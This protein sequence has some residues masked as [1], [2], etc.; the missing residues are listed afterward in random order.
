[1]TGFLTRVAQSALGL[2]PVLQVLGASRYAPGPDLLTNEIASEEIAEAGPPSPAARLSP[3]ARASSPEP[4]VATRESE[5]RD[6]APTLT[7]SLAERTESLQ[8]TPAIIAHAAV[9]S[10]S[11]GAD[12]RVQRTA[13][14]PALQTS[15][16][17]LA[18][19]P[20]I[21]RSEP[22]SSVHERLS[23]AAATSPATEHAKTNI[24]D[25]PARKESPGAP[26]RRQSFVA[27][28]PQDSHIAATRPES[29]A[30]AIRLESSAAMQ[31]DSPS[32]TTQQISSTS[33][34][35]QDRSASPAR[36]DSIA[37]SITAPSENILES[38]DASADPA[39]ADRHPRTMPRREDDIAVSERSIAERPVAVSRRPQQLPLHEQPDAEAS[40]PPVIRVTI[41]RIEVRAPAPPPPPIETPGPPPPRISLDDYLQSHN[42]RAR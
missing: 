9:T 21:K 40:A 28:P 31:P 26:S 39:V 18:P 25:V 35:R 29:S 5:E 2:T 32:A 6:P 15:S 17:K 34:P 13:A 30:S 14:N 3:A 20:Q 10:E 24:E 22:A 8:R 37:P 19:A 41:G 12:V 33:P 7:P 23:E 27:Q 42:G 36:R 38:F 16:P 11:V 1:M 4:L